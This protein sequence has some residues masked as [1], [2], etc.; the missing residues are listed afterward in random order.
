M[1]SQILNDNLTSWIVQVFALA[2]LGSLLPLLFR[3]RHP[4]TQLAYCHLVLVVCAVLPVIQPWRHRIIVVQDSAA[5]PA[6]NVTVP[7]ESMLPIHA[8]PEWNQILSWILI[9]GLLIRLPW[10]AAGLMKIRTYRLA[11]KPLESW[12]SSGNGCMHPRYRTANR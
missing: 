12:M 2:A 11:G 10:L 4:R 9:A 6:A 3:I 7:L 5:G 8:F 1:I